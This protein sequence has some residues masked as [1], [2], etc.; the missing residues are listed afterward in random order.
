MANISNAHK[1][2]KMISKFAIH[3]EYHH[4]SE[5]YVETRTKMYEELVKTVYQ[6]VK[7]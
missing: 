1:L 6:M 5:D 7:D 3:C 4:D 2:S